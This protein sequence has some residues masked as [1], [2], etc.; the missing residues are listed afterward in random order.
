MFM[1][2]L[3][4]AAPDKPAAAAV[5]VD[6]VSEPVP[7]LC[8]LL[9]QL[10]PLPL[11]CAKCGRGLLGPARSVHSVRDDYDRLP[12]HRRLRLQ[13]PAAAPRD[14]LPRPAAVR[15]PGSVA[16]AAVRTESA[17]ALLRAVSNRCVS[18]GSSKNVE[19]ISLDKVTVCLVLCTW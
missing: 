16:A 7:P 4:Q 15:G 2:C 8:W 14:H 5:H 10:H 6:H 9:R 13:P 12:C 18:P 3:L 17:A 1:F 19:A 11:L